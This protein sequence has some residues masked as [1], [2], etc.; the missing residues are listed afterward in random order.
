M[1]TSGRLPWKLILRRTIHGFSAHASTDLSAGLTYFAVL[2]S[3]PAL[4]ALVSVLGLLGQRRSGSHALL[5]VLDTVAPGSVQPI[6]HTL[7]RQIVASPAVGWALAIGVVGAIWSA[8]GYVGAFGRAL[9]R[10][11][12]VAE[13]RTTLKLRPWQLLTTVALLVLVVIVVLILIVSGP[14]ARAIGDAIGAGSTLVTVWS[15]VKWPVLAIAVIGAVAILYWATPNVRRPAFRWI[16]FG[17]TAAVVIL[18][19]ASIGFGIY[20]SNFGHYD[21]TYGT[22]GGLVVLL[23]WLWI[24]NIALLFGAELDVEIQRGRELLQGLAAEDHLQMPV[25]DD[26]ASDKATAK[27]DRDVRD[28][29]EVRNAARSPES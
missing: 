20:V 7:V 10:V 2:S 28:A 25:R 4:L 23:L 5:Q 27:H 8:S 13:G 14:I 3:V 12:G 15:I 24:A 6:L 18:L 16:S 9:N 11:Y 29:R 19:V 17:A 26:K 22:L 1:S 21:R